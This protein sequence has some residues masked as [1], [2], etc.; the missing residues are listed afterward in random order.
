MPTPSKPRAI[1]CDIDGTLAHRQEIGGIARSPY[2]WHRV[3]EDMVDE[4]IAEL[5]RKLNASG[6]WIA[7]FSGRDSV[8]HAQTT[9][10]LN[11]NKI[12]YDGLYMRPQGDNRKDSVV[13]RELYEKHIKDKYDV[14]CVLDDRNQV[15][16]MWREELGLTCL[17]VAEGDF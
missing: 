4:N 9:K 8:C 7:I 14:L 12:P 6:L 15:V 5:I 17:Q 10:W 3:S 13:K 11:D 2:D 16:K 1:I